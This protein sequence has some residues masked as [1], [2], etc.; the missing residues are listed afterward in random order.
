MA[1]EQKVRKGES[2]PGSGNNSQMLSASSTGPRAANLQ[3]QY[4]CSSNIVIR[5][6]L[7]F[8][9]FLFRMYILLIFALID[10]VLIKDK[11]EG[12]ICI[13]IT[14]FNC[15][16]YLERRTGQEDQLVLL[17]KQKEVEREQ[18]PANTCCLEVVTNSPL[19]FTFL[20]VLYGPSSNG[21][22]RLPLLLAT[23]LLLS[24]YPNFYLILY[25]SSHFN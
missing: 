23:I 18:L 8:Q 21:N 1:R 2:I 20:T 7:I 13:Q 4:L 15:R 17:G 14:W 6:A 19:I 9:I 3:T 16:S 10:L 12:H 24:L 22:R 5:L 11:D 25:T